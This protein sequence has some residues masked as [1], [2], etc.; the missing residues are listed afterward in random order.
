MPNA[1]STLFRIGRPF[2]ITVV[3][4]A[5]TEIRTFASSTVVHTLAAHLAH[6]V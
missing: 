1:T 3:S 4:W 2:A 5:Y 6:L